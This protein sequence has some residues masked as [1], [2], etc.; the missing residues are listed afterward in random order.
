MS[1]RIITAET[2]AKA[3]ISAAAQP[4]TQGTGQ[5]RP[6][7]CRGRRAR[8][9]ATADP[10]ILGSGNL[11][12]LRQDVS[13]RSA[14][15]RHVTWPVVDY[16]PDPDGDDVPVGLPYVTDQRRDTSVAVLD[17]P[18]EGHDL[19]AARPLRSTPMP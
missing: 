4:G 11:P 17:G 9:R 1:L 15:W 8:T 14:R 18:V 10:A 3:T 6:A 5:P 16:D 19:A 12:Q 2:T 13:H 7:A